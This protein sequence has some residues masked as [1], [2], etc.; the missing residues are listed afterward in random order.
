M[1]IIVLTAIT[2]VLLFMGKDLAQGAIIRK[3]QG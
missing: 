2:M 3:W 1:V